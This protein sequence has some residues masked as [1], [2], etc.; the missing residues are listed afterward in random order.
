MR[1]QYW[2]G[3]LVL[4]T[5][6]LLSVKDELSLC[7]NSSTSP[8]T[9]ILIADPEANHITETTGLLERLLQAA[10]EGGRINS[11]IEILLCKHLP[12]RHGGDLSLAL[13]P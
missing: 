12:I 10:E 9:R 4:G 1:G 13:P 11:M 8:F 3:E 5:R 2:L 6:V 7:A